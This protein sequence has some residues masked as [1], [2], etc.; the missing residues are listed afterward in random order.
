MIH[1]NEMKQRSEERARP[2]KKIVDPTLEAS[3]K[4]RNSI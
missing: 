4:R 1:Y 3:A 2:S